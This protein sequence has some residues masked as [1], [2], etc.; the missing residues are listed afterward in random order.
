MNPH[1]EWNSMWDMFLE[2]ELLVETHSHWLFGPDNTGNIFSWT[3][4]YI[5]QLA[6]LGKYDLV[7]ADGSFYCQ[8]AL[9]MLL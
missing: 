1:Y 7:T 8:V 2:D 3:A 4:S 6:L 5:E 9:L